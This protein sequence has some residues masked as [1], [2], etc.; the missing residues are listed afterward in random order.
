MKR[1]LSAFLD[2]TR[3]LAAVTVFLGHLSEP[4]FGGEMLS[5]FGH[6]RHSAVIVFFVL[7]GFVIAWAA[8]RDGSVREYVIN[9]ATRI[10]SVALPALALTWAIDDFLIQY[11]PG[12]VHSLYQH[13]AVWKYLPI[14]LTFSTD[15][16][17]LSEDAFSDIPYWSLCYE[18]WYYVVFGVLLFGRGAWRWAIAIICLLMM[19]PRLWLLWPVWLAGAF[20]HRLKPLSVKR[21]RFLLFL[22]LSGL[23]VLKGQRHRGCA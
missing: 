1:D 6:Q 7:S 21:S 3:I 22:S 13:A 9:R 5:V 8:A 16:W 15:F 17:F 18:V 23:I 2:L 12:T 10:Y 19:G 20:L 14:F 11:Y 4:R